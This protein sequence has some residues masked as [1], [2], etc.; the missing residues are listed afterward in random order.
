MGHGITATECYTTRKY[1][2]ARD[3]QI[4]QEEDIDEFATGSV[5][6]AREAK[7]LFREDYT[8]LQRPPAYQTA[9][10]AH[11]NAQDTDNFLSR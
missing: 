6:L 2:V 8:L 5:G 11:E 10:A 1:L 7:A 4:Q 9:E 3:L